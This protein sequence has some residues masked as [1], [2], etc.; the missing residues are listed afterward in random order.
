M[1][2]GGDSRIRLALPMATGLVP[3]KPSTAHGHQHSHHHHSWPPC[4]TPPQGVEQFCEGMVYR[5][6]RWGGSDKI[7][8]IARHLQDLLWLATS[9]LRAS[10]SCHLFKNH[11]S[12][13][14]PFCALSCGHPCASL[15]VED[16]AFFLPP[17]SQAQGGM[18][19]R[20]VGEKTAD[21]SC[22]IPSKARSPSTFKDDRSTVHDDS[23][24]RDH[25]CIINIIN[26]SFERKCSL[27]NRILRSS[28]ELQIANSL[29]LFCGN[30][31]SADLLLSGLHRF[32]LPAS[33][34]LD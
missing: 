6:K 18:A 14:T 2:Q 5:C 19:G 12:V 15:F 22:M 26:F 8:R 28:T 25:S 34:G 3:G 23:R 7:K 24:N 1:R 17:T 10:W 20:Q 4:L 9:A 21:Q 11:R 30:S 16:F 29:S 32:T 31:Q 27:L 33:L 13:S